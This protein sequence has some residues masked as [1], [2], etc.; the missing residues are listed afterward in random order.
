MSIEVVSAQMPVPMAAANWDVKADN[1]KFE[2]FNGF[3]SLYAEGGIASA[4]GVEIG[5]GKIE[6][7]IFMTNVFSFPGI[8]FRTQNEFDYEEF[9]M[10]PFESGKDDAFQYSPVYNGVSGWQ[11]YAGPGFSG[12]YEY[13]LGRWMHVSIL[14]DGTCGEVYFGED[15]KPAVIMPNLKRGPKPGGVAV[16]L[17]KAHFSNFKYSKDK[18]RIEKIS[19]APTVPLDAKTVKTWLISNLIKESDVKEKTVLTGNYLDALKW[20]PLSAET[21]AGLVNLARIRK[22]DPQN[23]TIF[24]K[25]TVE[26]D[27][28]QL[29]QFSFGFSDRVRL[30]FDGSLIFSGNDGFRARDFRF[31]GTVGYFHNVYLP[32]RKG[33]NVIV[34]AVSEN[35]GGW[36]VQG[37]FENMDG[38]RFVE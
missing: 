38:I 31:L 23:N 30:Y 11:L 7:D 17:D 36:G 13:P 6:F 28:E 32:L 34:A 2:K 4:R 18:P 1:A 16:I 5:D 8:R 15:K 21:E 19:G 35:F 37:K 24:A 25:I 22:R 33:R 3:D 9:Y 12:A 14:L 20:E 27:R 26:S 10:R 29:K